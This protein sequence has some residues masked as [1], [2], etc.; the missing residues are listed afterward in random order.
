MCKDPRMSYSV[1]GQAAVDRKYINKTARKIDG[2]MVEHLF[3]Y[4]LDHTAMDS[5]KFFVIAITV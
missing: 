3:D 1:I 2:C 5:R 4:K